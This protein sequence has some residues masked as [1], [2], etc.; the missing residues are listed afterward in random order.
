MSGGFRERA[1]FFSMVLAAVVFS[2]IASAGGY[3]GYCGISG[4]AEDES[5]PHHGCGWGGSY[6]E[7]TIIQL[8]AMGSD[9]YSEE[10]SYCTMNVDMYDAK[11]GEFIENRNI[12][13]PKV[14][15]TLQNCDDVAPGDVICGPPRADIPGDDCGDGSGP[16]MG[17]KIDESCG[18]NS[19]ENDEAC[20]FKED[21]KSVDLVSGYYTRHEDDVLIR[22]AG[23]D[24]RFTRY[25]NSN[26]GDVDF[27]GEILD[28]G[29]REYI[30]NVIGHG[31]RHRYQ[32]RIRVLLPRDFEP[33]PVDEIECDKEIKVL[34]FGWEEEVG[35][36]GNCMTWMFTCNKNELIYYRPDGVGIRMG[37]R[38]VE[39]VG[40][41]AGSIKTYA[42]TASLNQM[43]IENGSVVI[44]K[45]SGERHIFYLPND[46]KRWQK[47]IEIPIGRIESCRSS[48][49]TSC[50]GIDFYYDGEPGTDCPEGF[51]CRAVLDDGGGR[52]GARFHY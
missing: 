28:R 45:P 13:V 1:A 10:S 22:G 52:R 14:D 39:Q 4:G 49:S 8:V 7:D 24:F 16:N 2:S 21:G 30:P 40:C 37:V 46:L 15:G 42:A 3:V 18:C 31:W 5:V 9:C 41:L 19:E 47:P 20:C 50:P 17:G 51:L 27:R 6:V 33:V 35:E 26:R 29:W 43:S 44:T 12:I 48:E 38:V 34:Q 32:E 23:I 25:Y 36:K 11:T